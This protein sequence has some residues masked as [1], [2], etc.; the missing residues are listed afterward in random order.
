MP[1]KDLIITAT[2]VM[3]D[4]HSLEKGT[5]MAVVEQPK[6]HQSPAQVD[7][8]TARRWLRDGWAT[9]TRSDAKK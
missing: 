5:R 1:S 2:D 4:G 9:E 3:F 8:E 7:P 6:P